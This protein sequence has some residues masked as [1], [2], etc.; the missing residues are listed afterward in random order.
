MSSMHRLVATAVLLALAPAMLPGQPELAA[1][2]VSFI[3][4]RLVLPPVAA[5][6]APQAGI[7]VLIKPQFEAG[8][9]ALKKGIV[10]DETVQAEV[11]AGIVALLEELGF[12][13]AGPVPSPIEGG[14]GNREF[15]VGAR[16]G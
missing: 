11:C 12:I 2:D 14:D 8:R 3:S 6:L 9:A 1:I 5:L 16:R 4:L 7:A 10:R 15:L 13:V